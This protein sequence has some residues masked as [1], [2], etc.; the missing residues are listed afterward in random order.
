MIIYHYH[1][2]TGDFL[3]QGEA[4]PSPMEPGEYLIPAHATTIAPPEPQTGMRRVFA[5]GGWSLVEIPTEPTP[6]PEPDPEPEA[7]AEVTQDDLR[8]E[9]SRVHDKYSSG[10]TPF[11][12]ADIAIDVEARINARG[13]LDAVISGQQPVPFEWFAGGETL[14]ISSLEEMQALHDA[15]FAALRR[16]YTAKGAVLAKIPTIQ[17][18]AAYSVETAYIVALNNA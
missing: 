13:V 16:G 2:A 8:A 14:T 10:T 1:P 18:P 3:S 6:D 12:G 15:I 7:P 11:Q 5:D 9:L 17:D 4:D